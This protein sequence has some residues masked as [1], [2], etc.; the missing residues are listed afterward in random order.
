MARRYPDFPVVLETFRECLH[1]HLD[2]PAYDAYLSGS[3]VDATITNENQ[4]NGD[5]DG[6][7][8]HATSEDGETWS[9][10][11]LLP[12][13]IAPMREARGEVRT[14]GMSLD[15]VI[16][17]TGERMSWPAIGY[18][19]Q[20]FLSVLE[21]VQVPR[22]STSLLA[23]TPYVV[24]LS[25]LVAGSAHFDTGADV[26][27]KPNGQFQ[28]SAT[29]NPDFGQ[30]ESDNLV[31]NF[32]AIETFFSDRRPF[33]TENQGFFDVPFG[34][35]GNANRLL[36]TRRVG[37][38]AGEGGED[39]KAGAG[40]WIG[41]GWSVV[42]SAHFVPPSCTPHAMPPV[43][44]RN[45]GRVFSIDHERFF[46]AYNAEFGDLKPEARNGLEGLLYLVRIT[47]WSRRRGTS[48]RR[49]A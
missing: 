24:G 16:G 20:R 1:G 15:R 30:V 36:Y 26:F 6:D 17:V 10:E 13:H 23:V 48:R 11:I 32:G 29:L 33:F 5:W 8:R 44:R 7:W 34:G 19:E 49:W 3:I 47:P 42:A 38:A 4:V 14:L 35:M 27:W 25:D 40:H 41:W 18:N 39:A 12:W 43:V 21:P 22:F 31:V 37:G 2:L 9:A 46:N 28:L 45:D